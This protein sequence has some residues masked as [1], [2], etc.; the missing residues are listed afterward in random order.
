M[1]NSNINMTIYKPIGQIFD[2]VS[3]PEND[4]QWQYGTLASGRLSDTASILGSFF[5]SVGHSMGQRAIS[6]FEV[7]EYEPNRK[8]GFKS[9]S[10]PLNLRTSYT[11]EMEGNGTKINMSTQMDLI[12]S[13]QGNANIFEKRIKKQFKEN[14]ALL[15]VILE[16]K[17]TQPVGSTNLSAN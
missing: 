2:F 11:F 1:I 16:T 17:R 4:S 7:T 10:G 6:T 12:D 3:T 8:Y 14:L 13:P 15:K 9:L 5:R